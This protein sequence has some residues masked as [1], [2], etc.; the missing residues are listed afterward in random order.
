MTVAQDQTSLSRVELVVLACHSQA[1]PPSE[2]ELAKVIREL[3][4][5]VESAASAPELVRAAF[6]G[7]QQRALVNER[8]RLTD[9]GERVLRAALGL[10]R[11]PRWPEVRDTHLPA[12]A[13]GLAPGAEEAKAVA[14][15]D[16]LVPA[17]LRTTLGFPPAR[18]VTAMCDAL[19]ADELRLPPGPLTLHRIRAHLLARRSGLEVDAKLANVNDAKKLKAFAARVAADT[20]GAKPKKQAMTKALA[21]R[22]VRAAGDPPRSIEAAPVVALPARQPVPVASPPQVPPETLLEVVRETIP[23]VGADGRFGSEKVFVSAIWRSIERDQR[24]SDLSLDRFKTWL[25][26]ANRDGALVLARADL[27]GAM[28][29][30]QVAESE[31]RDR[32]A[33]FHFVLDQEPSSLSQSHRGGHAR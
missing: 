17:T 11:T 28:D 9:E 2:A 4:L 32:N 23:N 20:L 5:T 13:L 33:T 24:L 3:A 6:A 8:R 29:P 26:S 27:I 7:L 14:E 15:R 12:K 31:I 16:T 25:L 10:A 22:W 21:S 19:I 30:K 18:S 1:K